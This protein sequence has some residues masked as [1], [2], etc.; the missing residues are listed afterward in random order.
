MNLKISELAFNHAPMREK[1]LLR[2]ILKQKNC[3]CLTKEMLK[4]G[5]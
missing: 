1:K 2:K 4:E 5:Y 3:Y